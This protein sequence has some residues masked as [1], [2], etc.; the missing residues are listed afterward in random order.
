MLTNAIVG[1]VAS[2]E[3]SALV[4]WIPDQVRNDG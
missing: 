4:R 3:M 1:F 2:T